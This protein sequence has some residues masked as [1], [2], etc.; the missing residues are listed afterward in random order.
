MH[1]PSLAAAPAPLDARFAPR[2]AF[3]TV[4]DMFA[5]A[6]ATAPDDTALVHL[7]R[8][9]TYAEEARAVDALAAKLEALGAPGKVVAL[10]VANALEYHIGFYGCLKCGAIPALANA[11]FPLEALRPLLTKAKPVLSLTTPDHAA[12]SRELGRDLSFETLVFGEGDLTLPTLIAAGSAD[13]PP[14]QFGADDT[15]ILMFSGGT[16]GISKAILH[17]HRRLLGK[18]ERIEWGWPTLPRGDVWLPIAPFFHVYGLLFGVLNPVYSVGTIVIPERFQPDLVVTMLDEHKVTV[19]GGGPPA[20]Y[21]GL[22]AA[23]CFGTADLSAL[24]VCPGGG[25]PFPVEL[26]KR[27]K[28]ATGLDIYEGY[29]MTEIAPIAV[30][31][32]RFGTRI[33]SVGKSVPDTIV[34]A[35]DLAEGTKVLPPGEKGELRIRGP[36]LFTGYV[37]A[38]EETAKAI[39]DG[40]LYTGDIGTVDA[41]GFVTITDRKKDVIFV[42]GFNVFPRE[43]EEVLMASPAVRACGVIGAPDERTGEKAVAFVVVQGGIDALTLQDFCAARLA[44]YKVPRDIRIVEELPLTPAG[45]LDRLALIRAAKT[46]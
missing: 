33:G 29:G 8:R 5:H 20:I 32:E 28:A 23:T 4:Y 41:E 12:K 37:D 21:N 19:F 34:E 45:K 10:L 39:R 38:P 13:R 14:A 11:T 44:P 35:V 36:H 25:A 3:A 1:A 43:I 16:T 2:P 17:S 27:W 40:F 18:V 24:R 7:G 46:A 6:V 26:I 42:S 15:A 9:L 22:L 30:N 31:T